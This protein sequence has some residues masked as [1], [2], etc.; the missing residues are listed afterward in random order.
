MINT[1]VLA[2]FVALVAP[3]WASAGSVL[4]LN[5]EFS[6]EVVLHLVSEGHVVESLDYFDWEGNNPAPAGFDLVVLVNGYEYG[7]ELGNDESSPAYAALESYVTSGGT[8][9]MTE[10][11][12]YDMGDDGYKLALEP[13]VP[14]KVDEYESYDYSGTYKVVEN[15]VLTRGLPASFSVPAD[16]YGGSCIP[17]KAGTKTLM[18]RQFDYDDPS[19]CPGD[20]PALVTMSVGAGTVIWFNSDLGHADDEPAT[21]NHL[22][23]I[24]NAVGYSVRDDM[25]SLPVPTIP[26]G[27]LLALLAIVGGFGA[28]RLGSR[29]NRQLH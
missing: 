23:V 8:F 7:Y 3:C 13:L 22:K 21:A 20:N 18:T 5:D 15:S 11:V 12:A 27:G 25:P 1:R 19:E 28:Y 29:R 10:W 24:A 26:V 2:F 17:L 6:D 9:L 14:F 4:V 16:A